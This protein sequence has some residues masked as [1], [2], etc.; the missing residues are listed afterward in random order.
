MRSYGVTRSSLIDTPREDVRIRGTEPCSPRVTTVNKYNSLGEDEYCFCCRRTFVCFKIFYVMKL[1]LGSSK[2]KR[3]WLF[4]RFDNWANASSPPIS[5][6][7]FLLKF[8]S[9]ILILAVAISK[10]GPA[11][12]F[13]WNYRNFFWHFRSYTIVCMTYHVHVLR[14]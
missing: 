5:A 11:R 1:Y 10:L 6:I 14:A 8:S 4:P 2:D 12:N 9:A 13:F 3:K 7:K